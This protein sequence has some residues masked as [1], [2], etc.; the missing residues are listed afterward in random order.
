MTIS[1]MVVSIWKDKRPGE[2]VLVI[3]S[4][5]NFISSSYLLVERYKAWFYEKIL[6]RMG[7][8]VE[9]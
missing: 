2:I 6:K 7:L 5:E 1:R 8:F 4:K 9:I 3:L